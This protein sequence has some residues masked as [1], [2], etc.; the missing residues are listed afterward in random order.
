MDIN[1]VTRKNYSDYLEESGYHQKKMIQLISSRAG[2]GMM[3]INIQK[4]LKMYQ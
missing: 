1:L 4:E 2:P 3:G